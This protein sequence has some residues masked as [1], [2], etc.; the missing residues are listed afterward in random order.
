[1]KLRKSEYYVNAT[2]VIF[3]SVY[4]L[5]I[6]SFTLMTTSGYNFTSS[7]KYAKST[8]GF[9]KKSNEVYSH[10]GYF[11]LSVTF[12]YSMTSLEAYVRYLDLLPNNS[13]IITNAPVI[14]IG[15]TKTMK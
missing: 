7:T 11:N 9:I 1:M 12:V 13:S 2:P 10:L 14:N 5:S 8:H 15:A 3:Y 6:N 4:N